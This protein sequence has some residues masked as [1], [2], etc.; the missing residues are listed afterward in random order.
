MIGFRRAD[1]WTEGEPLLDAF[2]D[3]NVLF[4]RVLRDA[5]LDAALAP[6][7][8]CRGGAAK[9]LRSFDGISFETED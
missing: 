8:T 3:T 2:L 5:L 4:P 6:A 1:A 7:S 9:C